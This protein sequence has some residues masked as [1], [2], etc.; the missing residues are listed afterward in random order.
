[1]EKDLEPEKFVSSF[2]ILSLSAK[3]TLNLVFVPIMLFK[4][5]IQITIDGIFWT[6][7]AEGFILL[8]F[9]IVVP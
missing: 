3:W 4:I 1:M 9:Q 2:P 8:F 5:N 7:F 6:N